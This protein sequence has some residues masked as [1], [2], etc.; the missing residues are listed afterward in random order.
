MRNSAEEPALL[1][2]TRRLLKVLLPPVMRSVA[3]V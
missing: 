3:C 1:R 2:A